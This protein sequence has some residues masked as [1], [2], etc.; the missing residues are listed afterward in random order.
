MVRNGRNYKRKLKV[1]AT[2][3]AVVMTSNDENRRFNNNI[4]IDLA[5]PI[6][7]N[8]TVYFDVGHFA[9]SMR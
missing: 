9:E 5:A 8:V 7:L 6:N 4:T 1:N 3:F 2:S